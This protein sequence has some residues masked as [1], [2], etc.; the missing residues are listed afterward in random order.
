MQVLQFWSD[1]H[2]ETSVDVFVSEPFAFDEEALLAVNAEVVSVRLLPSR[3]GRLISSDASGTPPWHL[4]YPINDTNSS[5]PVS[6]PRD[7]IR[8]FNRYVPRRCSVAHE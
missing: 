2:R 3:T 8:K 5:T 1:A 4:N 7:I 6:Q